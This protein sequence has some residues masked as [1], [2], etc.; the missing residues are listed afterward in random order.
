MKTDPKPMTAPPLAYERKDFLESPPARVL[1]ILAEYM[2][3]QQRF[4]QQRIHDTV[5][6]FGSARI[7]PQDESQKALQEAQAQLKRAQTREARAALEEAR[8]ALK[9]SRY[10]E[11][12]RELARLLTAWSI[13]LTEQKARFVVCS[14]GGP[15]IMEAANRG[16]IEAQ[17]RSV[18]L[19]ITLPMEQLPNP[20]ITNELNLQFH[21]FFMRKYWFAYLAKALIAFPGGFGTLDELFEVLTLIQTRKIVKKMIVLIYGR[22]YWDRVLNFQEIVSNGMIGA[23]DLSLFQ[24]ADSPEEAFRLVKEGLEK[25]YLSGRG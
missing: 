6:F 17:G 10:Y 12:A 14:G 19:G 13:S 20:Y 7:K 22:K 21:Y 16:A 1:R 4:R 11:E 18:G 15:G 8:Q 25:N 5:V 2:E 3:P 24:F 23:A 9:M